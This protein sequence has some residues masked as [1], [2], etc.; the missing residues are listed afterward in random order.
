MTVYYMVTS[1]NQIW[2]LNDVKKFKYTKFRTSF[3]FFKT[4]WAT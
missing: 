4:K 3:N 1:H 2:L